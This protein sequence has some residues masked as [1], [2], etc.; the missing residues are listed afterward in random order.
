M[1]TDMQHTVGD[2]LVELVMLFIGEHFCYINLLNSMIF[3]RIERA[4]T[5]LTHVF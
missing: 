4:A 2:C 3:V 5:K 1:L